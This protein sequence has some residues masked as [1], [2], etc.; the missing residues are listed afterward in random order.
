M[1]HLPLSICVHLSLFVCLC[2]SVTV[3]RMFCVYSSE[4]TSVF[5]YVSPVLLCYKDHNTKPT[6]QYKHMLGTQQRSEATVV[7]A[8]YKSSDVLK[9]YLLISYHMR[10]ASPLFLAFHFDCMSVCVSISSQS[11]STD[12][13]GI[14]HTSPTQPSLIRPVVLWSQQDV[15]RWLKKHCPHNYLTYVEVFSQHAIT[16]QYNIQ[17]VPRLKVFLW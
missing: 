4:S 9:A 16:G 7:S 13:Y 1:I 6:F 17:S 15:C 10:T 2:F 11:N 3:Y 8:V 14:Y 5:V 12:N